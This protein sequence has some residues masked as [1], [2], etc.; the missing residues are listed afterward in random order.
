MAKAKETSIVTI[1]AKVRLRGA[2]G[3]GVNAEV[4]E[5]VKVKKEVA[6]SLVNQGHAALA[7]EVK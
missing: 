3:E 6:E 5:V 1:E 7:P 2:P 4:G